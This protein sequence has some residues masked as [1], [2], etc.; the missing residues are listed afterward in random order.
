MKKF[1]FLLSAAFLLFIS[2]GADAQIQIGAQGSYLKGT[3]DNDA[4]LWGGGV[5]AKFYLGQHLGFG[6]AVRVYP[7][8]TNSTTIGGTTYTSGNYLT[9]VT[10]SVDFLL[11]KKDELIQPYIGADV[12]GSFNNYTVTISNGNNQDVKNNNETFFLISPKAGINIGLLPSFGVFGQAMY[13]LTFGDGK[14]LSGYPTSFN[15]KPVDKYLTFD[16]GVYFRLVGA[17]K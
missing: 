6:G 9:N 2:A 1:S 4:T 5:H 14:D 10:G 13:N 11:G 7:K 8:S 3:G 12:G 15:T 16:V 17:K